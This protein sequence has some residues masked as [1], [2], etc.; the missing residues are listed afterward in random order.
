MSVSES[1]WQRF[2]HD[3]RAPRGAATETWD[4][5]RAQRRLPRNRAESDAA[6]PRTDVGYTRSPRLGRVRGGALGAR[7]Y[8]QTDWRTRSRSRACSQRGNDVPICLVA[9]PGCLHILNKNRGRAW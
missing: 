6:L 3:P 9:R 1:W 8:S 2:E 7:L 4:R 5:A